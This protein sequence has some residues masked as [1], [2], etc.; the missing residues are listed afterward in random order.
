MKVEI[1]EIYNGEKVCVKLTKANISQLLNGKIL[2]G[3]KTSIM[4]EVEE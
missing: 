4:L 1:R 3:Y 2:D